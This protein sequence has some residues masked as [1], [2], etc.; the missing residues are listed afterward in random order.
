[1]KR[2]TYGKMRKIKYRIVSAV[3]IVSLMLLSGC[4]GKKAQVVYDSETEISYAWWGNDDRHQYTLQALD[5]F[6]Q[7]NAGSITVQSKYGSWGGY[8]NRM[9]IYMRS[10]NA[11]DVMQINYAWL[12]QYSPDGMG[13]YDLYD[14]KDIIQLDNYTQEE[15]SY[16]EV[17]GKL[18]AI[19]ISFNTPMFYFNQSIF[20]SYGLNIPKTW[21]ELFAAAKVM[22]ADEIYP[23]GTTEK[24]MF[25]M[26]IVYFEQ[27]TGKESVGEDGTLQLS[28]QDIKFMLDFYKRLI[29]EKVLMPID[30]FS[31][32]AFSTGKTAGTLAWISDAANYC[33]VLQEGGSEVVIGD[34]L[35]DAQTKK[36]GWCVKPAT[37]YAISAT[38]EY[39]E[40]AARLLDFLA[41]SRE[42]AKLQ[43]TEKG[44]P[45][46]DAAK[47]ALQE[48]GQLDGFE[49]QADAMREQY[50]DKLEILQ[51]V[52]ESEAVYDGF[53][54]NADYYIY[55]K[56]SEDDV[57]DKIYEAIY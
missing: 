26:L 54:V 48:D 14:L 30:A 24:Q 6:A 39:P 10:H 20:E 33:S 49:M 38:T 31:R 16:G 25:L 41:N 51:P 2:V 36:F 37:M 5:V 19:P 45:I 28:K 47:S 34:Y 53:K 42:M 12:S 44:I 29:D 22:K 9:H 35:V 1:M 27:M 52:L 55:D 46:S 43:G 7:E 13:F 23:L 56:L 15:L 8:E 17:D 50:E 11:P 18:N 3:L 4:G 21:E 40:E 32:N 57:V